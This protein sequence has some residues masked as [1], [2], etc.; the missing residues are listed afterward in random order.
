MALGKL[1]EARFADDQLALVT[2][3]TGRRGHYGLKVMAGVA[4]GTLAGALVAA[5]VTGMVPGVHPLISG[6][7]LATFLF[8]AIAGAATGG[9]A[10]GLLSMSASGDQA[11]FYEQ[12][13]ESGRFL[14]T[15]AGP[16]LEEAW[17]ILRASGA[18]EAVPL[19]APLDPGRPRPESG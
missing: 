3:R 11:L 15:V 9:V 8:A 12:E 13:V 19:E 6:N 4:A 18:M 10:G 5:V 7:L 2:P 1:K 17:A 14:V 16:R